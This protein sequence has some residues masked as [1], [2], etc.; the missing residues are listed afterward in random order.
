MCA[1]IEISLLLLEFKNGLASE[2][3]KLGTNYFYILVEMAINGQD[4]NDVP[5]PY[6][7]GH[8]CKNG[9]LCGHILKFGRRLRDPLCDRGQSNLLAYVGY[10][11]PISG[12]PEGPTITMLIGD[13]II[14]NPSGKFPG[15]IEKI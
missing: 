15:K 11:N 9:K 4:Q 1:F 10:H 13:S 12:E 8:I 6:F 14:Y 7:L 2:T 3:F 5:A